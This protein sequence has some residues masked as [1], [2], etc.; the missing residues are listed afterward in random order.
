[1][2]KGLSKFYK[3]F[4]LC[5]HYSIYTSLECFLKKYGEL[6]RA[7]Q[8]LRQVLKEIIA[9]PKEFKAKNNF[10]YLLWHLLSV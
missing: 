5:L 1:M 4:V 9:N 7:L 2:I 10:C 8:S 6:L 3:N